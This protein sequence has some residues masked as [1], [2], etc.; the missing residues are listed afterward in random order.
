MA[1][2]V[3]RA[4]RLFTVDEYVRMWDSGI[5]TDD[6]RIELIEGEVVEMS[7]TGDPHGAFVDNLAHLLINAV[8]SRARVRVQGTVR[9][10]PRSLPQP[11]LA[12]LRPRS[13]KSESATTAD[14]LLVVEV[15]DTSLRYD[16]SVK[17][18]LYARAGIPEYWIVDAKTE[19]LEIYRAPAGDQYAERQQPSRGSSIAPLAFPDASI[20]IDAIFV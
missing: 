8:G 16:R 19:T 4:R 6:D 15:A 7:P 17:L 9:I 12:V 18:R 3:E 1:V 10:P 2:D 11:D 20:S 5:F 14:I 13:Y